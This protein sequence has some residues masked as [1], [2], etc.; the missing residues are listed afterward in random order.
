MKLIFCFIC[1]FLFSLHASI[2]A[3]KQ[4]VTLKLEKTSVAEAIRELKQQ[5]RL[6]FFFSNKE[7]NVKKTVS[8]NCENMR[9]DEVLQQLLGT[10]FQFEF[11]DNMVIITPG[12]RKSE[13]ETKSVLYKGT[14][15]DSQGQ[16]L[17]GVTVAVKGTSLGVAT[18]VNGNFQIQM[19]PATNWIFVFS[20]IGMQ[21]V[22]IQSGD[23]LELPGAQGVRLIFSFIGMKTQEM[24]YTG[25]AEL[26]IVMQED[27][28]EMDEVVVTGY[29]TIR[30]ER[31]TGTTA[32][33]TANQIAGRGLQSIDEI[34]N[35]TI[36]GL[37]MISSGRPG[38]DAQIQIRGVNSL[39]GS[40]EP[41]WI[42]DGMP[43]QGEI[44]NIQSGSTDLQATI[45]TTGIGNI[46][47]DDIKSITVLK[48]AAATAIYGARAANGVIV[49][50]TKSGLSGKT[51]FN[52]SVN[53]G[54]TERPRNNIDMMNTAEKIQFEREIFY[55]QQGY[56][57]TP[58]RVTK[59][60]QQAAYG[61]ISSDEAER[62]I[63]ELAKIN[64]DWFKEITQTPFSHK[65]NLSISG[66][67]EKFSHHTSFNYEKSDGLQKHN[68]SEKLMARTNIRQSLL[69]KWVDLD[70]NLNII[71][72]KYSPSSTSAFMQAF[73]HNPT[74]PVY[75]DSDPDAGGYSRIKAMEY[76]NPVA[77]I[78]ERNMESKNDNY[79]ANIRA[80]L[81]ILPIKGLKWE[82]F[83]SY[84]K[85][86]Y[87]T[88]EYYT[89]YYPSL[90][91]TNGQAY[92]ENY[93]E[94]DT[95]YESTLNYSNIFGKHSIQV[96]LGYTYQ[97]TYSTSA[98]MT[99]SGFDFDDNQTHN[100]G[101]GTNLTEGKASMSSNKE[102][103]TYIGFFGRFMYNYD[104]KYLL[105]ASLRRDGS[106]RFGDNN[107]WGWFPAV[108]VG[109]RINKEKF[110]SNVKWIDDLKLR[111]GYGVTG[112][113]DFSNYKSL[114]M[115]TTAGKFYYNGQWI[116][117]YQP[118]SNA[119]PDLKWEK[120]AEF[121]VGVDMTM[122]DNRLSFTFD[123]YKRTTS[124][125]LYDYIVPTPPYVYNTL[126]T[127]VGKVTNEG[128]ELTISG[129]P[130]NTRDFTWNTSLTVSHNKNKLVKFTNDE[131]TNGTYKVGW[132]TSAACYTQRLIEGQSLG[133]F[134]GPIWLGTDTDGKDVLLG[135]NAD[136]SVPEE[137]WEKIG[138]AY[139]DATLS[140]SNTF[141]YKKFDLSFSLR[142][143]IGGEILNNYAMEY[144]N[145]S[146]IGLRN[147][148]SNWLSQTNF[149]S[150][151]YKYSSKYIE[152][153]SYLKLDNVTFGYTWD[154]TS[155]MIKRLRLS[156]TAQNVFCITGYSGVDPEVALS[157]LEPGME[158][159]SYYPRTTEFTFGVNIVF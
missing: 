154:F 20:F 46:V 94:N 152:D 120:K 62:R 89:H 156:L 69:D 124:N 78:N 7:V 55:D 40:T 88:R 31:M 149:T 73:T 85:E 42:V 99:N 72:R 145:L 111:A 158:S 132:S 51:R 4:M 122:F 159:L 108:S 119:N 36:S 54:I 53:V 74:E 87:E 21:T 10:E 151:T 121:N 11:V 67:S 27:I 25:Q 19:P 146:S 143:S 28:T 33:I 141:R 113:Q 81:N 144:E 115:M 60:L 106:S 1:C 93:Q 136:G 128:V 130:F 2:R 57:Y 65:H 9:I 24:A 91:G 29:Q 22:E 101:T 112:N 41:M 17:P 47:P 3:Q 32:T 147:I 155:K 30:K 138:C 49:V 126:F 15:C 5:T 8:L 43:L 107:K 153:A 117:T 58:G 114:M 83:V 150:T 84:D 123:Y 104:D 97:Y 148:S 44:P 77:I 75:D 102:D 64:T 116:N 96:L 103:N 61:E 59:L 133:T 34:L 48:D 35:S 18:D 118:A 66:G 142:A 92:I 98:S 86:Q 37:N 38:Q 63:G 56:I 12:F 23:S 127:N 109:W 16:P 14:V 45:F 76:Y 82:N 110:L 139:P 100:I 50:E 129:T 135:Q 125:L 79:G 39:T 95:Q 157:G 13:E 131:F 70:Y 6:D 68:S 105:S 90:I 80:T 137:Q 52:A 134:Y 140:W 71:H 26:N